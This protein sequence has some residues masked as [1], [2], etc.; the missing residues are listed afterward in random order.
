[1]PGKAEAKR[2]GVD[3]TGSEQREIIMCA[4]QCGKTQFK[5]ARLKQA[6][7]NCS[8]RVAGTGAPFGAHLFYYCSKCNCHFSIPATVNA[9]GGWIADQKET[10]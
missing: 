8:N 3:M 5:T 1:M 7:P 6:C 2:R 4:R 9:Q 10:S